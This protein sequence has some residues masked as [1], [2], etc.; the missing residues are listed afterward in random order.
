MFDNA[1]ISKTGYLQQLVSPLLEEITTEILNGNS[2]EVSNLI[3][4][5]SFSYQYT[6]KVDLNKGLNQC[7]VNANVDRLENIAQK[8]ID[9]VFGSLNRIP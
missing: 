3:I 6:Y 2:F 8:F 7:K 9:S 4:Q 5:E 1:Q